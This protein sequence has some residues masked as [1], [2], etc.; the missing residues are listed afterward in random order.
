MVFVNLVVQDLP[1][2]KAFFETLGLSF[3]PQFTND[4][5]ACMVVND[6]AF[7]MI[8]TPGSMARFSSLPASD[9]R[10]HVSAIFALSADSRADVDRIADLALASGGTAYNPVSDLGFMYLRSFR[11]PNGHPWEVFWMD[12]GNVQS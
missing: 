12:P 4:E 8:H 1:A 9:P 3:N 2:E 6:R 10:T 5:A 11:D 7:F